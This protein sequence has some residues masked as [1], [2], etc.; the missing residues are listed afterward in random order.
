MM[1][2]MKKILTIVGYENGKAIIE[3]EQGNTYYYEM[4][5]EYAFIGEVLLD[6][7]ESRLERR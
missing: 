3:D 1:N 6:A 4:P 2:E 5:E 7:D